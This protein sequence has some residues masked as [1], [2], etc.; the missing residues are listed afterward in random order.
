MKRIFLFLLSLWLCFIVNAQENIRAYKNPVIPGMAPN[1]SVCRVNDDYYLVTSSFNQN[2]AIPIYHSKNLTN[3]ELIN[4]AVTDKNGLDLSKGEGIFAPTIRYNEFDSTFYIVATNRGNGN[5]FIVYTQHPDSTWSEPVFFANPR[6]GLYPSLFWDTDGSCYLQCVDKSSIIQIVIDPKTGEELSSFHYL[7]DGICPENPH[8]YKIG[9]YYYLMNTD[10][11]QEI[12]YHVNIRMSD[13]IWGPFIPCP[14]NPI[15]SHNPVLS[16]DKS[17]RDNPIQCTGHADMIQALDNTWLMVFSATRPFQFTNQPLDRET[18][19]VPIEW[20]DKWPIVNDNVTVP[21]V[22]SNEGNTSQTSR[23]GVCELYTFTHIEPLLLEWNAYRI[24]PDSVAKITEDGL[25]IKASSTYDAF[26]GIRQQSYIE[27]LETKVKIANWEGEAGICVH[28][29]H[30]GR[31]NLALVR[32]NGKAY[33]EL[34]YLFHSINQTKRIEIDSKTHEIRLKIS[35][36]NDVY[37][38]Y[39]SLDGNSW[40]SIDSID[41]T[42]LS[43]SNSGLLL[44]PYVEKGSATFSYCSFTCK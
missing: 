43:E 15:L 5:S 32:E 35:S 1:P 25:E 33:V 16:N 2:P 20:K 4:Y 27:D 21:E 13:D 42:F 38:F 36:K 30:D 34:H 12:D 41:S 40:K 3:W 11:C 24:S 39:Y 29:N 44:G 17:K 37:E 9:K 26:V 14:H 10:G 23:N 18:F 7:T 28:N 22:V 6:V 19:L 8:M 31:Y